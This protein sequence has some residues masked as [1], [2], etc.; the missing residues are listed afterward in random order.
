MAS[1]ARNLFPKL[2]FL[3]KINSNSQISSRVAY[4]NNIQR[5]ITQS[6]KCFSNAPSSTPYEIVPNDSETKQ[7]SKGK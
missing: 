1:I 4:L 6:T 2:N 7:I 3:M 5:S